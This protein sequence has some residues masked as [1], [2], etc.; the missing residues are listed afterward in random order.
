M[1][2]QENIFFQIHQ[3]IPRE[4]PGDSESTKK[5]FLKLVD[6]PSHPQ[7]LDIG[8]GP[9]FQTLDLAKLTNGTIIAIDNHSIYIDELKQKIQ[10]PGLS[11][12]IEVM[13]A[14]MFNLD[15]PDEIFDVIWSEGSIYIIG[16]AN[17]L[18]QWKKLLKPKGY[19]VASE[20]TW[21]KPNAP[22]ELA[23]FWNTGYPAMQ[24]IVGNCQI[25]QDNEYKIIDYFVIPESGW[26][27]HYYQPLEEKLQLFQQNYPDDLA[28]LEVINVVQQEINFYRQYSEYYGY[29][30]YIGQKQTV[31]T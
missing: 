12:K 8:C 17:G 22:Q 16:F 29:V 7:I 30:F 18:K 26:W 10:Q 21:L 2:Q 14:D 15:F 19:I 31:S 27:D 25:L 3:G 9:G 20:I 23:D 13:A 4:G 1:N 28:V 24:D 5:A 6:L 11:A